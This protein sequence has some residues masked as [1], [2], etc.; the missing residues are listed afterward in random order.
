M[1]PF[2]EHLL[3]VVTYLPLAGAI[4]LLFLDA[5]RHRAI[6]VTA[7]V[8]A[9]LDLVASLPLWFAW[10]AARPDAHGFRFVHEAN[11]IEQIGARYVVGV[12][13]ISMLLVLLTTVLG[14][15]AVLSSWTAVR[16]GGTSPLSDSC[17]PGKRCQRPI[18]PALLCQPQPGVAAVAS[19]RSARSDKPGVIMSTPA[20]RRRGR[21]RPLGPRRGPHEGMLFLFDDDARHSM[22]MKNCR[23]PL[24][25]VWLD[26]QFR[27]ADIAH[28]LQPCPAEGPCPPVTPVRSARYVL[29]LAG[30]T[31]A[32]EKLAAGDRVV[33]LAE[34]P[35]P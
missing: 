23:V 8:V 10:D 2:G 26:A 19:G 20:R 22:W 15:V 12:D 9:G 21:Q 27:V 11:W 33:V 16:L 17:L 14:F 29:E 35:L 34:P 5:Q 32:R 24:D 3:D 6:A 31:A 4:V 28:D 18:S 1:N 7:T 30:G 13:G 25:I